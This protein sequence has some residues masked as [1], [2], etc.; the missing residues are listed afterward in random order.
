M[1]LRSRLMMSMIALGWCGCAATSSP[2][3]QV[4]TG[5]V[6][7]SDAIAVVVSEE[8]GS[9]SIAHAGRMIR[10]LDPERLENILLAF[11]RPSYL[12]NNPADL[13]SRLFSKRE[14]DH[15]PED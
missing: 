14:K 3:T 6:S 5:T 13:L 15:R 4:V 2:T 11:Y 12:K 9:I 8:T 7:A 10:R 1:T